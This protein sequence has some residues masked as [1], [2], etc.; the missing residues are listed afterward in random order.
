MTDART[1][2]PLIIFP[3]ADQEG[4]D[5]LEEALTIVDASCLEIQSHL[6]VPQ[7]DDEWSERVAPA[8]GILLGWRLPSG[9][10]KNAKNLKV[11]SY[12]GT[13]A[14]DHVDLDIAEEQGVTVMNV[15]GYGDSAV[16][17]HATAL[18]FSA[19]RNVPELDRAVRAGE[20]P[21]HGTWQLRGR[22]LGVV[23]LGGVG[24]RMAA[25]GKA[26]GMDVVAWNRSAEQGHTEDDGLSLLPLDELLATSDAVSLHVPLNS[27]TRGMIDE[28]RLRLMKKDA[29]L[30]NTARGAVVD[31]EALA[32]VLTEGHLRAAAT[33]VFGQEPINTDN[34]LL[35]APRVILTPHVAFNT[36]EASLRLFQMAL[37]NL[38]EHFSA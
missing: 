31:E 9:A 28:R 35:S 8:D 17:E 5:L 7:N 26:I 13:G 22:R 23:G 24:R 6:D 29:V 36:H 2:K 34:P 30:V 20:W 10:L 38:V 33:D 25:I 32:R 37:Q 16:A 14:S 27:D 11:I 19:V 4:L 18:L 3:D 12:L 21:S 15:V 1:S